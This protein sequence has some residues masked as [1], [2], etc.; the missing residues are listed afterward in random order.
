[1]LKALVSRNYEELAHQ[2]LHVGYCHGDADTFSLTQ[3]IANRLD[4]YVGLKLSEV[5]LPALLKCII[6]IAT[7]LRIEIAPG[8]IRM[9][10]SLVLLEGLTEKL[11]PEFDTAS[12]LEPLL[13]DLMKERI[14]P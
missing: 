3:S 10:R 6:D 7:E 1:M 13:I 11:D 9:T 2:V 5:D 4:P 14:G 8:F 12:E